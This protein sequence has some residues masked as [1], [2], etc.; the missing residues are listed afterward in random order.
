M[1]AICQTS[2]TK[3][4][5]YPELQLTTTQAQKAQKQF[6]ALQ[7]GKPLAQI[8]GN[9][10]FFGLKFFLNRQVFIPRPE[11]EMLVSKILALKPRN[12]LEI[13]TGSGCLALA[14]KKNLPHCQILATDLSARALQVARKNAKRLKLQI[15]FQQADLLSQIPARKFV[16][17]AANL[18]YVAECSPA[19]AAKVQKFEPPQALFGG[20]DGLAVI[21]RLIRQIS[22]RPHFYPKI[23]LEIGFDQKAELQHFLQKTCPTTKTT[24]HQDLAGIDRVCELAF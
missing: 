10:E 15:R 18:P 23:F 14:V 24:F 17:I 6:Q 5:T 3:I 16:V 12:L 8:L 21:K 20:Q 2:L 7:T 13:G 4:Y 1:A 22:K 9:Q 11:T 19:L